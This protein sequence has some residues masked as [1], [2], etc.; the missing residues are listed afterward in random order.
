MLKGLGTARASLDRV[1]GVFIDAIRAW[2]QIALKR[3]LGQSL[4]SLYS[5]QILETFCHCYFPCS[6]R[7][8]PESWKLSKEFSF[9]PGFEIIAL[10]I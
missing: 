8:A 9:V 7:R 2:N 3:S 10:L 1:E 4:L 5:R 6:T